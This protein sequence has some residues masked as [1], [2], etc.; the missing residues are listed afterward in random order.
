[1]CRHYL[2]ASFTNSING[3]LVRTQQRFAQPTEQNS[4][5]RLFGG[6]TRCV[7]TDFFQKHAAVT[8]ELAAMN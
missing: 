2:V 4:P 3:F 8:I 6:V 5:S 1:M 7:E